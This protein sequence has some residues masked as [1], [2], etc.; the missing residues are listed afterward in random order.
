MNATPGP[1]VSGSHFLPNAPL[2]CTKWIPAAC[3]TSSKRTRWLAAACC[4]AAWPSARASIEPMTNQRRCDAYRGERNCSPV[5]VHQ[6]DSLVLCGRTA[7]FGATDVAA[8][9]GAERCS[10]I[11]CRSLLSSGCESTIGTH[12]SLRGFIGFESQIALLKF[13]SDVGFTQS[14]ISKASDYNWPR[15]LRDRW[16]AS[17]LNSFKASA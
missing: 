5:K 3:V 12:E 17:L 11:G 16:Q 1:I 15:D 4:G 10:W 2:L 6:S 13:R 8:G 14:R 7:Y 9:S